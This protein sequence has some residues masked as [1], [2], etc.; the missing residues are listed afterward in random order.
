MRFVL[1]TALG[2]GGATMLGAVLGFLLL[3][4]VRRYGA[5]VL[6]FGGGVMLGSTFWGLIEPALFYGGEHAVFVTV[7][8]LI[9]GAVGLAL[10]ERRLPP[11]PGEGARDKGETASGAGRA[12]LLV[13]AI[14]LH[15]L[16]EGIA[17]GVGFATDNM[18][19]ALLIAGGIA[20]QN[21]PEGAV[22]IAPMLAA[23]VSRKKTL[24]LACLTGAVEVVG[25]LIGCAAALSVGFLLPLSL[26]LAGG[27]MLLVVCR[28]VI[29]EMQENGAKN[30]PVAALFAGF[31]LML[32]FSELL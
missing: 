2:V 17:A 6:G 13:P 23:G 24:L 11:L 18:G 32:I 22:I 28:E 7:S 8:G 30:A 27:C 20:L 29:P 16:P 1:L 3:P 26:A 25:V 15:N 4:L 14:A 12:L 21:L 10:L 31:C 9:V 5:V 19:Q